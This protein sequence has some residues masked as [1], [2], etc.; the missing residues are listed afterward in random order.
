M[1]VKEPSLQLFDFSELKL[2][3][4]PELI[5]PEAHFLFANLKTL[6]I[7]L[8]Y[9]PKAHEI[10]HTIDQFEL[11]NKRKKLDYIHLR[12]DIKDSVNSDQLLS[13]YRIQKWEYPTFGVSMDTLNAIKRHISCVTDLDLT[14]LECDTLDETSFEFCAPTIEKLNMA[15]ISCN[16]LNKFIF[17]RMVNLRELVFSARTYSEPLEKPE[18]DLGYAAGLENLSRLQLSLRGFSSIDREVLNAMPNLK[19]LFL[20][21]VSSSTIEKGLFVQTLP[22][23][24]ELH[25]INTQIPELKKNMFKPLS[26][27]EKLYLRLNE[28]TLIEPG[29]FTGLASLISLDLSDNRLM[30][31]KADT[32]AG[33]DN[34]KELKIHRNT[35]FEGIHPGAFNG[36]PNV[37][38]ID[39]MECKQI[40]GIAAGVF[41]GLK[42]MRNLKLVNC[43]I[44]FIDSAAFDDLPNID[45]LDLQ[46]NQ[47]TNFETKCTPQKL[48]ISF[49]HLLKSITLTASN[50][51][52]IKEVGI[53][54]LTLI[55]DFNSIFERDKNIDMHRLNLSF[56][57]LGPKSSFSS[58]KSLKELNICK[59]YEDSYFRL[60]IPS[61]A[62]HG[63]NNL[64]RLELAFKYEKQDDE[65]GDE[66]D[67]K[68][69]SS[70]HTSGN[71]IYNY[72]LISY[73]FFYQL[74]N[75]NFNIF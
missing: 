71:F 74:I 27:L 62:F 66:K 13:K 2:E 41:S 20:S 45:V 32:F 34:L 10:A 75:H 48:Y 49:N 30:K 14:H 59:F 63:L 4:L 65:Q 17:K 36:M 22:R 19:Y 40:R 28:M 57:V 11:V 67:L 70:L 53:K 39:F 38:V 3:Y 51:S 18:F 44:L 52:P 43:G 47:L 8:E 1:I 9:E 33:L 6:H 60:K 72:D 26:S 46:I 23:L 37:E 73:F 12:C 25:L 7:D 58:L 15:R 24:A 35:G 56:E 54:E 55:R 69:K 29:A 64:E 5:L 68:E 42:K 31:L 61:S 21:E 16:R 50:L